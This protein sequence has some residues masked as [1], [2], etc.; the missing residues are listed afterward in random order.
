VTGDVDGRLETLEL[1][2][3]PLGEPQRRERAW[4]IEHDDGTG[5][6]D[7]RDH[8]RPPL[9]RPRQAVDAHERG[10]TTLLSP[11]VFHALRPAVSTAAPAV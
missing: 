5:V 7:P 3:D 10:G 11:G 8:A 9:R 2:G 4:E 6:L 1:L